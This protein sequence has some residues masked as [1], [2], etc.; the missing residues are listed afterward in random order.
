MA[1]N[2]NNTNGV[3]GV[4]TSPV[5]PDIVIRLGAHNTVMTAMIEAATAAAAATVHFLIRDK[6]G[7]SGA[8]PMGIIFQGAKKDC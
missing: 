1:R 3:G 6:L 7:L 4:D 8:A 2:S 5:R